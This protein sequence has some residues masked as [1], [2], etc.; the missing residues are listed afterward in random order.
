VDKSTIE[1]KIKN[2]PFSKSLNGV[3]YYLFYSI[4]AKGHYSTNEY[5]GSDARYF[6]NFGNFSK[7]HGPPQKSLEATDSDFTIISISI[8][9]EFPSNAKIDVYVSAALMYDGDLYVYD[10]IGAPYPR[11]IPGVVLGEVSDP[12]IQTLNLAD[13]SVTTYNAPTSLPTI[14]P[15]PT[16]TT[17]TPN[18]TLIAP[19]SITLPL[20]TFIVIIIVVLSIIVALSVLLLMRHRKNRVL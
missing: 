15:S 7:E 3:N 4:N 19:N 8:G 5:W 13:G 2:Q 20:N 11:T 14:S 18:S 17:L 6:Y 1:V 12:S 16:L 9:G 10:Y